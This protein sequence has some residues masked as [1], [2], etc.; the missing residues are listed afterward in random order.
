MKS[1]EGGARY[2]RVAPLE[3]NFPVKFRPYHADRVLPHWHEHIELLYFT[4]GGGEVMLDGV[5]YMVKAGDLVVVNSSVI[6]SFLSGKPAEYYCILIYPDFFA[7]ISLGEIAFEPIVEGDREVRECFLALSTEYTSGGIG[8]DMMQKSLAYR[9]IA[10]LSRHHASAGRSESE[11]ETHRLMLSRFT[12]VMQYVATHYAEPIT[13]RRL[14]E[15]CYLS[16]GHF[17]RF[18]KA[19]TGKTLLAYVNE[20]RIDRAAS[21]LSKTDASIT[22]IAL[23]CGFSDVNYFSRVFRSVRGVSPTAHR[24]CA[25]SKK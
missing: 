10:H 12:S 15:M 5:P 2:E 19:A 1:T 25:L 22:E 23:S 8:S 3:K 9:L 14:A 13:T 20:Y 18:F 24:R 7:D 4:S 16:E 6:H 21:L 17:C 11:Q